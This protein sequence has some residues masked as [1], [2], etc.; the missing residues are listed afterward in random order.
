VEKNRNIFEVNLAND[1]GDMYSDEVKVRQ[2]LFNLVGNA[3]KFSISGTVTLEA[4]RAKIGADVVIFRVRDTGIGIAP[5]ELEKIFEQFY[6]VPERRGTR[7]QAG[8][9]LGLTLCKQMCELLQGTI[10]AESS[11][12]QGS[13]FTVKLPANYL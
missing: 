3:A 6:Q 11:P 8:T 13:L 9:G 7:I 1:M 5:K 12:G 10:T 4:E 2:I